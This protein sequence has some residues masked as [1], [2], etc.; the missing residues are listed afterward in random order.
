MTFAVWAPSPPPEFFQIRRL[1]KDDTITKNARVFVS[2]E[3]NESRL[4]PPNEAIFPSFL[5]LY[6]LNVSSNLHYLLA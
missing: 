6:L 2:D 1:W 3:G 4:A 5:P